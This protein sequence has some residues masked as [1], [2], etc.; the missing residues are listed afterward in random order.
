MRRSGE[1][2]A[3]VEQ[4]GHGGVGVEVAFV[5]LV[6]QDGGGAGEFLVALEPLEED[7]G[8]DDLDDGAGGDR[9]V[10]AY[11]VADAAAGLL[12]EQPGHAA[13][14]GLR[15]HAARFGDHD[16]PGRPVVEEP[17]EGERDEG[18]LA[19]AGGCGQDG[20]AVGVEGVVE[21]GQGGAHRE[22]GECVLAQDRGAAGHRATQTKIAVPGMTRPRSGDQ[23]PHSA[24]FQAGHSGSTRSTRRNPAALSS[25]TRSPRV[26]WCS[27]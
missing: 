23:P 8:G 9:A 15:G 6:E 19:G 24:V 18:G 16:G 21:G 10:A 26:R 22:G 25:R 17:G 13:G 7:A 20:A 11:G 1:G 3:H 4:E 2:G 27:T 14:G 5:A 12:A